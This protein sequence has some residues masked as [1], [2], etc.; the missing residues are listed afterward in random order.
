METLPRVKRLLRSVF[1]KAA[2]TS[3]QGDKHLGYLVNTLNKQVNAFEELELTYGKLID[4]SLAES[5]SSDTVFIMGSGPSISSLSQPQIEEIKAHDS[6]GFNFSLVHEMVP[7]HYILQ[8]PPQGPFRSSLVDLFRARSEDY[9][10][11]Q[12]IVRGDHSFHGPLNV[13]E[14]AEDLFHDRKMWL[15]PELA[16]NS[17]VEL[18]PYEMMKFFSFLGLLNHGVIG[19]AVPKWRGTLGLI[20]SLTYQMGYENIVLCGIDM[21][22]STHFYQAPPY[23]DRFPGLPL[24]QPGDSNVDTFE[25]VAYSKNTVSRYVTDFARFANESSETR[26][27]LASPN[28]RLEGLIPGWKFSS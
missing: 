3:V 22:D 20:L 13:L 5:R 17:Q 2:T 25:S 19:K 18:D 10:G 14:L 27:F 7:S 12:I 4:G 15:L 28:S 26:L 6:V 11:T 16:I 24:P 21:N 9:A 23:K 8:L 1:V